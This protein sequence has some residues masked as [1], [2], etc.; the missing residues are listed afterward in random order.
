MRILGIDPGTGRTGFGVIDLDQAKLPPKT[1]DGLSFSLNATPV[2]YG[3]IET[4]KNL[5]MPKR[6]R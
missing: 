2:T 5:A 4:D 6:S 3:C 1:T